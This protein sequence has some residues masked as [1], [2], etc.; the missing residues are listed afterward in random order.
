[1]SRLYYGKKG[2][3]K[4]YCVIFQEIIPALREGRKVITNID[5]LNLR[6]LRNFIGKE[7]D[8]EVRMSKKWWR[9]SLTCVVENEGTEQ[10]RLIPH[11]SIWSGALYVIDECQMIWDA[12]EFRDTTKG[13]LSMIEYER[14]FDID[15]IFV[16]QNVK[17]CDVNITRLANDS[18]QI[19]NLGF[20]HGWAKNKFVVNK[21]QTPFDSDVVA[22]YTMTY[23]K[24]IFTLYRSGANIHEK[25]TR[26]RFSSVRI[27]AIVVLLFAGFFILVRIGNP[28]T[29]LAGQQE[30]KHVSKNNNKAVK[31]HDSNTNNLSSVPIFTSDTSVFSG[32]TLPNQSSSSKDTQLV[33]RITKQS[34]VADLENQCQLEGYVKSKDKD[35]RYYECKEGSVI[36][37]NGIIERIYKRSPSSDTH[38]IVSSVPEPVKESQLHDIGQASTS[39]DPAPLVPAFA[40]SGAGAPGDLGINTNKSNTLQ[41]IIKK[42]GVKPALH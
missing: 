28:L 16:T 23:D 30:K 34:S 9:E 1:M 3:G 42:Q 40:G 41:G 22:Q 35:F 27:Y 8:V 15:I 32:S 18:F 21:R 13:F 29:A 2:S 11:P 31:N 37:H 20:L 26:T 4:S 17:R 7:I 36:V 33:M 6:E 10:E 39:L 19:K 38:S 5:G 14:H 24:T 12:R 25:G